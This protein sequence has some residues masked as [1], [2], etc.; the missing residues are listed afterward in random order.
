MKLKGGAPQRRFLSNQLA[1][2]LEH[3]EIDL[4]VTTE[5]VR[6]LQQSITLLGEQN[7][8]VMFANKEAKRGEDLLVNTLSPT[9]KNSNAKELINVTFH[10]PGFS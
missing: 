1:F 7:A 9:N 6:E 4:L 8:E 10:F 3:S 5:K 2:S